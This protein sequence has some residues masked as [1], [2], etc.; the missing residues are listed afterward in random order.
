[1]SSLMHHL[2][3]MEE[4]QSTEAFRRLREQGRMAASGFHLSGDQRGF[5]HAHER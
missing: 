3:E 1:M 5:L 2:L 4:I